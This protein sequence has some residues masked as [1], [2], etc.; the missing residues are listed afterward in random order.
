MIG[1]AAA[2]AEAV[3]LVVG[4]A[5]RLPYLVGRFGGAICTLAIHHF[6]TLDAA[7]REIQRVM[8]QGR[9]VIFTSTPEQIRRYWLA[10]YFPEAIS[11]SAEQMPALKTLTKSLRMSGFD[12]VATERY[13]VRRDL[14]D[15][16]L[17]S[18]KWRPEIYL[19]AAVRGGISTFAS[20][21]SPLEVQ[22]GCER[23]AADMDSGVVK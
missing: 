15:F 22:Y 13:S 1:G 8:K 23:L 10:E 9:F 2:E 11:K 16:F 12:L 17:Y 21:A 6:E 19:D 18:G 7:I 14:R 4:R 5:D 3:D 20:L